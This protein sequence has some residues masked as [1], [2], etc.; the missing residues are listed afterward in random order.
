ML[1]DKPAQDQGG[2]TLVELLAAFA[3]LTVALVSILRA[4]ST[5]VSGADKA[6]ELAFLALEAR[7]KMAL[8]GTTIPLAPDGT[9]RKLEGSWN[10]RTDEA[11][12]L[13]GNIASDSRFQLYLVELTGKTKS[14]QV[15]KFRSYKLGRK[16]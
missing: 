9:E 13:F 15:M 11:N 14:G 1:K 3:I 4:F 6:N 16:N 12:D 8:I 5:G 2:F 7:S 10:F